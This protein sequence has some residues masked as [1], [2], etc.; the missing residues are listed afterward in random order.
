MF[1]LLCAAASLAAAPDPSPSD[2]ETA[3]YQT[4]I[5]SHRVDDGLDAQRRIDAQGPGFAT[6]IDLA[7]EAGSRP[8]DALP[9]VLARSTGVSVRSLGG[10]GQFSAVSLRGSTSQQVALFLDGIPLGSSIGG[11]VDLADL[12]LDLLNRIEIYRGYVPIAFGSAAI[13]GVINLV[14]TPKHGA[15]TVSSGVAGGSYGG[16]ELRAAVDLALTAKDSLALRAG[17]A[18]SDGDF[19]F[20]NVNGTP[21]FPER[22]T[23][24][25]RTNNGFERGVGQLVYQ[26]SRGSWRLRL[27]QIALMKNQGIPGT[28]ENQSTRSNLKT[29]GLQTIANATRKNTF[30]PGGRLE[31]AMGFGY[32]QRHFQDPLGEV[33]LSI[34]DE[35]SAVSDTYVSPR[36]RIPLWHGAFLN[37]VADLRH[38]RAGVDNRL[39][40]NP[41]GEQTTGD[42]T[43][44]RLSAGGGVELEQYLWGSRVLLAPALRIERLQS[45]F[46]VAEGQGEFADEGEDRIHW[47]VAPRL[48]LRV[49]LAE[50]FEFRASGGRYLRPPNLMELFGDRGFITGNEGLVPETGLSADAGVVLD[51]GKDQPFG[52]YLQAAGFLSEAENLIQWQLTGPVLR[53][54]NIAGASIAGLELGMSGRLWRDIIRAQANYTYLLTKNNSA[55]QHTKG[56][57][58]A[59]RPEHQVFARISGGHPLTLGGLTANPR[60]FYTFEFAA[61]NFLDPS[62]RREVPARSLHGTGL[63]VSVGQ[64]LSAAFE[65]RN[66]LHLRTT[67]W[68]PA[69]ANVG[70]LHVP[71]SDIIGYPLPG[72]SFWFTISGRF[73]KP[74]A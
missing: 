44:W 16:K 3:A 21:S 49:Q 7:H 25:A 6:A 54:E 20:L 37:G 31:I 64:W 73:G 61:G 14:A 2:S 10:L 59:G 48:G 39:R 1:A 67:T 72:R 60:I 34:D 13:G 8:A 51:L 52:L 17:Y 71:L 32:E 55:S 41:Q 12:P 66:L 23:M 43:R 24:T 28:A 50:G 40:V 36:L 69:F 74:E 58:L 62:G 15:P 11:M 4:T 53:P 22:H 27:Q 38:E 35:Q 42:A 33:G 46:A 19:E 18:S 5:R 56:K 70:T 45:A 68:T 26:G 63:E 57:R 9:E 65:V 47:G 30:G 29:L